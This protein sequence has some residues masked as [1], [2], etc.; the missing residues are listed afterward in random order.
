LQ[1]KAPVEHSEW[2]SITFNDF[3]GFKRPYQTLDGGTKFAFVC[4]SIDVSQSSSNIEIRALFH[5]ARS[6]VFN[7]EIFNEDGL[8]HELYHFHVTEY[9]ARL[10]RKE[11]IEQLEVETIDDLDERLEKI[12]IQE[13]VF[14]T[15]YDEVTYHGYLV[16][17]QIEW[18][19][20]IDSSLNSL[21]NY[22]QTIISFEK[23]NE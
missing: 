23:I 22:S 17:K 18:Q 9:F 13:Q 14:Q 2:K 1:Y 6:Y 8:T 11:L 7:R 10:L 20:M 5:P 16:G 3:R 15:M 12:L 21:S 4:T 19:E